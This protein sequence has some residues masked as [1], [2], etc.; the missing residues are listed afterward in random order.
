MVGTKRTKENKY[1]IKPHSSLFKISCIMICIGTYLLVSFATTPIHFQ[2]KGSTE[3]VGQAH[4]AGLKK[5]S[6]PRAWN[7]CSKIVQRCSGTGLPDNLHENFCRFLRLEGF[8]D[9]AVCVTSVSCTDIGVDNT[10]TIF[11]MH[12]AG[13]SGSWAVHTWAY[14]WC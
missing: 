11:V 9:M 1:W 14:R 4:L 12:I 3:V 10:Q 5:P 8:N 6:T 2:T 7:H 13:C